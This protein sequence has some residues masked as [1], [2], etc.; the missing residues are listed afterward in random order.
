MRDTTANKAILNKLLYDA[1]RDVDT[2]ALQYGRVHEELALQEYEKQNSTKVVRP[3]G[4]VI[5]PKHPFLAATPDGVVSEEVIVGVKCPKRAEDKSFRDL[6]SKTSSGSSST[7]FL[8]EELKLKTTHAYYTQVQC[9]LACTGA[10]FCD[11]VVWSPHEM[12]C[13]RIA[14]DESFIQLRL[15]KVRTF[16]TECIVPELVDPRKSRHMPFRERSKYRPPQSAGPK[17]RKHDSD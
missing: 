17:K 3:V 1:A 9:Q 12:T 16:Y 14:A 11:F 7:F 4:L 5:H 15:D 10:K 6:A 13:Q 8:D 2:P